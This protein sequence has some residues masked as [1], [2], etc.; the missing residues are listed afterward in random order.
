MKKIYKTLMT[1]AAALALPLVLSAQT[2]T[3]T[4]PKYKY[5]AEKNMGYNKYLLSETPD[6][7]GEYI[8]RIENFITGKVNSHTLP[9]DFVLVL[10]IS[11]SMIY[12]HKKP[13]QEIPL[14]IK[15]SENDAKADTDL[16][17][18]KPDDGCGRGYTHYPYGP[19]RTGGEVGQKAS[20]TSQGL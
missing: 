15:K 2:T 19:P 6:D 10:D 12:D 1:L 13:G 4:P 18:L 8:L 5:D 16:T 11:G 9:T 7:N 14:S 17:K 3:T 20:G